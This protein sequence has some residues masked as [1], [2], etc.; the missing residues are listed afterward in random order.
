MTSEGLRDVQEGS[1]GRHWEADQEW[2]AHLE[3]GCPNMLPSEEGHLQ[4]PSVP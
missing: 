2:S 3:H 1:T 4:I